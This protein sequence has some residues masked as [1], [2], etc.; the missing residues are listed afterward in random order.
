MTVGYARLS[1]ETWLV[2][3]AAQT[4]AGQSKG[5]I[6]SYERALYTAI[7]LGLEQ[8]QKKSEYC[9]FT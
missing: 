2:V 8:A 7:S 6:E 5:G 3:G 4:A 1:A 9:E